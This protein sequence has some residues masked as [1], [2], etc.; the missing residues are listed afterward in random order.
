[1]QELHRWLGSALDPHMAD[2]KP[3]QQKEL[4]ESF[5]GEEKAT[6]SR[7]T[8]VQQRERA[9][10]DAEATLTANQS[11]QTAADDVQQHEEPE[12]E[13]IDAYDLAE[14]Q[15]ILNKLPEGFYTHLASAKWK[16]RKEMA[17][18]PLLETL[19]RSPRIQDAN[20]DE[21]VRALAGRMTD[22]N[23]A[24]VISAAGCIE[25]LAKGLRQDFGRY[26]IAAMP[27]ILERCKEK[28]VSVTDALGA[29]LDNIL[30]SV[31]VLPLSHYRVQR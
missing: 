2:L 9:L 4:T 12:S 21:L 1:M 27:P 5:A 24:C 28:K 19:K 20:Y 7:F 15:A 31:G 30:L 26:K 18:D 10:R 25:Y 17:L 23:I 13:A 22:A 8:R 14:P 11:E 6:Q 16:D 29:A 3:V